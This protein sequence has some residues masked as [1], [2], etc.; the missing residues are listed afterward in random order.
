MPKKNETSKE[1]KEKIELI[2]KEITL[3]CEDKEWEKL[4]TVLGSLETEN[5]C[6]NN[7]TIW[8]ELAKA[9]PKK[10]KALPTDEKNVENK[11]ITNRKEEKTVIL[12]H[13]LDRMQE[14]QRHEDVKNVLDLAK[15]TFELW[16]KSFKRCKSPPIEINDLVTAIKSLKIVT[17]S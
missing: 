3:T 6:T 10:S 2:D 16:L 7:T 13:F 14:K 12:D 11:V 5:G 8:K 17:F 4:G 15:I 9:Y 1:D